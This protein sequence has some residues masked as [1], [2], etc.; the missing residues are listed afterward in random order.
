MFGRSGQIATYAA[1]SPVNTAPQAAAS[2]SRTGGAAPHPSA[3]YTLLG[4]IAVF[5]AW[6]ILQYHHHRIR[7]TIRPSNIAANLHN[8][9]IFMVMLIL[10]A[11]VLKIAAAKYAARNLPGGA[12]VASLL[13]NT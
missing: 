6:G 7:E 11:N 5:F 3:I 13:G 2:S 1:P 10:S 4:L 9:L 8:L 12:T